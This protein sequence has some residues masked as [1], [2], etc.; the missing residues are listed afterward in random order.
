[1]PRTDFTQEIDGAFADR[2]LGMRHFSE[3]ARSGNGDMRTDL[4]EDLADYQELCGLGEGVEEMTNQESAAIDQMGAAAPPV[5][6]VR[7]PKPGEVPPFAAKPGH[8]W[9]RT[10]KPTGTRAPGGNRL[11][12]NTWAQVSGPRLARMQQEAAQMG[13]NAVAGLG[14]TTTEGIGLSVGVGLAIG[15]AL[16]FFLLR[17][18]K[19]S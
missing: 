11:V 9:V 17:K 16:W 15:G 5:A 7:A 3:I 13:P 4:A 14:M 1:M 18:K 12:K 19:A 2:N 6:P 8:H 10:R